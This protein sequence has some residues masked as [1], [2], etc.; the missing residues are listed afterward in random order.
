MIIKSI[1]IIAV[2]YRNCT[3]TDS[4]CSNHETVKKKTIGMIALDP[5]GYIFFD[6]KRQTARSVNPKTLS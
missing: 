6:G 3:K 4:D 2:M 5:T 1:M